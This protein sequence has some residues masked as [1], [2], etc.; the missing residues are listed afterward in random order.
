LGKGWDPR[1]GKRVVE[2]GKAILPFPFIKE[3]KNSSLKGKGSPNR[4][5]SL[6][7]GGGKN[8]VFLKGRGRRRPKMEDH[9]KGETFV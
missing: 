9:T 6:E 3:K 7:K 1:R 8:V 4:L 5:K 2:K